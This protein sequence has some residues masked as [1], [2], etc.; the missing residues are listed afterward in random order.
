MDLVY[1]GSGIGRGLDL[2]RQGQV[3]AHLESRWRESPPEAEVREV[4]AWAKLATF[5]SGGD[6][7][8]I[9]CL[10]IKQGGSIRI[11]QGDPVVVYRG[12]WKLADHQIEVAYRKT[13]RTIDVRG[14]KLPEELGRSKVWLKGG[15]LIF[16]NQRF[17]VLKELEMNS[18]EAVVSQ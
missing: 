4:T 12:N 3:W 18:F 13:F 9:S 8:W 1:A 10:L 6:F 16:R 17:E 5:R 15:S 2:V 11:S 7:I 14:R